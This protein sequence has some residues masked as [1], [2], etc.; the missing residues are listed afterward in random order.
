MDVVEPYL[1]QLGFLEE[2]CREGLQPKAYDHMQIPYKN[3]ILKW[4]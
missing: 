3:P 4:R 1:L 2:L